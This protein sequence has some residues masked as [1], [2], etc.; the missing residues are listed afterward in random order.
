MKQIIGILFLIV[1]LLSCQD[2]RPQIGSI[3]AENLS[4][5]Q[6]DS[7]LMEFKFK[8]EAPILL[9]SANQLLIPISTYLL[10]DKKTY[11]KSRYR[12]DGFPRYWN[13]LFYNSQ[14]GATRLLTEDKI[15]ISEYYTKADSRGSKMALYKK[16]LYKIS[17][18]DF[19][20]DK[21]LDE[22]DPQ[23]LFSSDF[24]GGNFKRISPLNEH[25]QSF[26]VLP[27]N[28]QILLNTLKDVNQDSIF[29]SKDE[30]IWYKAQ[31]KDQ[32]WQ[33]EEIIDSI[34]RKKIENLY[35]DQWLKKQ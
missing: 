12:S 15:R 26:K 20:K 29:N 31:Y 6:I 33:V 23:F 32:D 18:I 35:F 16:V 11:T 25:L 4:T 19:N 5:E 17:D 9:D 1:M 21:K 34:G 13:M 28:E 8:Y 2:N 22:K 30:S 7:I 3:E 27:I 14:T 10:K 24:D